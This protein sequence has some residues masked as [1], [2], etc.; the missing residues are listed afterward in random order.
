MGSGETAVLQAPMLG[1]LTLDPFAL[2]D[3]GCC[4]AE[5]CVGGCQD[6]HALVIMLMIAVFHDRQENALHNARQPV[7]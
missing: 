7:G 5:L 4:P 3:D 1:G 2:F 6:V